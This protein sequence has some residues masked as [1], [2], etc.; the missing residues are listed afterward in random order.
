MTS[1]YYLAIG[2]V[3]VSTYRA[4]SKEGDDRVPTLFFEKSK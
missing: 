3:R 4:L 2:C 1:A